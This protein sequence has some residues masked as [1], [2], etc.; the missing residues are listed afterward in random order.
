MK[1]PFKLNKTINADRS[2]KIHPTVS[3]KEHF[4][5][6]EYDECPFYYKDE[7]SIDRCSRCDGGPEEDL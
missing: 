1:C 7:D 5:S 3:V 4:G 2:S 6:C